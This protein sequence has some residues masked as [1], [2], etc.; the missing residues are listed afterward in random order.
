[1]ELYFLRSTEQKIASDMLH[2]AYRLD[3]LE[4]NVEDFPALKIYTKEYGA[5][6]K[7][8]G[9]YALKEHKIAGAAWIRPLGE[10]ANAFVDERMPVLTMALKPEFRGQS[11]GSAMLE[12]LLLEAGTM[13]EQISVSVLQ[14]SRA[15]K[16]YEKFGFIILE[17]SDGKSPTDGSEVFTMLKKLHIKEVV[18]PSDGYDPRRWMD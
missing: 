1:M 13:Y 14:N 11:I 2:F 6:H 3:V 4:R 12:Q 10:E 18:R 8:M 5:T 7:D 17:N 15:V 9:I 16:F